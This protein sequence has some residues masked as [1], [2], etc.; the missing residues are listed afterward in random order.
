MPE[1]IVAWMSGFTLGLLVIAFFILAKVAAATARLEQNME[2]LLRQSG[3]DLSG[4][5]GREPVPLRDAGAS[6][7]AMQD[8]EDLMKAGRKI[9]A[10]KLYRQLTGASL[11][12]A[13][14]AVERMG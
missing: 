14:A 8:V 12:D 2:V 7:P 10:I 5:A 4:A 3:E 9:D 6:T 1:T 13:K 11:A